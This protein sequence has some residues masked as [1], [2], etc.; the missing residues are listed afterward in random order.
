VPLREHSD[1]L[2]GQGPRQDRRREAPAAVGTAMQCRIRPSGFPR[3]RGIAMRGRA[4]MQRFPVR[5]EASR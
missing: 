2:V 3:A 4:G 5:E 1:R